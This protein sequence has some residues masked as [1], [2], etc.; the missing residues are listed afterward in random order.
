MVKIK[1]INNFKVLMIPV[2]NT[3]VVYVQSFILSGYMNETP[4]KLWYLSS[5]GTCTRGFLVQMQRRLREILGGSGDHIK[6]FHK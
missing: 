2:K 6:R 5:T 1:R 4:R 3:N